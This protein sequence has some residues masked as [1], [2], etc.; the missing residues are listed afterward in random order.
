M[1][2][3]KNMSVDSQM[4][5]FM[6]PLFGD[7][8]EKTIEVQ[9]QKLGIKKKSLTTEEYIKMVIA[10]KDLCKQMAGDAIANKISEGLNE[11]LKSNGIVI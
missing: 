9:K 8:A 7:M 2:V 11:I 3:V 6:R 5:D 10:I 1:G 4:V